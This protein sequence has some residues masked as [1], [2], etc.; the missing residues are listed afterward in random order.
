M[1]GQ[2]EGG[3]VGGGPRHRQLV[4]HGLQQLTAAQGALQRCGGRGHQ[5]LFISD[6][7]EDFMAKEWVLIRL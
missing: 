3:G 4:L 7:T 5:T 6:S 1:Q 2:C